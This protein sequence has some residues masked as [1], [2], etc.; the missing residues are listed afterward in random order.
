VY[1]C[2]FSELSASESSSVTYHN[3]VLNTALSSTAPCDT[4]IYN[5]ATLTQLIV[6]LMCFVTRPGGRLDS[7]LVSYVINLLIRLNVRRILLLLQHSQNSAHLVAGDVDGHR[8][9]RQY[10]ST[11]LIGRPARRT[12]ALPV[13]STNYWSSTHLRCVSW[14]PITIALMFHEPSEMPIQHQPTYRPTVC[15]I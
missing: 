4:F 14:P 3:N 1:S 11:C 12:F 13:C 9:R 15:R 6:S 2:V 7:L 5:I 10:G 8:D